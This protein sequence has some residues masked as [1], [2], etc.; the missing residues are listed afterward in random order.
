MPQGYRCIRCWCPV[1]V[2]TQCGRPRDAPTG[3]TCRRWTGPISIGVRLG[4]SRLLRSQS[5]PTCRRSSQ[6]MHDDLQVAT[7]PRTSQ[8]TIPDSIARSILG[9]HIT[10]QIAALV[11][12]WLE[13]R[14]EPCLLCLPKPDRWDEAKT[15]TAPHHAPVHPLNPTNTIFPTYNPPC[16]SKKCCGYTYDNVGSGVEVTQRERALSAAAVL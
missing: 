14:P 11:A 13:P 6:A 10:F 4:S 1:A 2:K 12:R 8:A 3:V 16:D 9:E 15:Y 5:C 7:L